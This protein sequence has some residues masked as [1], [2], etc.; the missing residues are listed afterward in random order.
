MLNWKRI[1]TNVTVQCIHF[2]PTV[3]KA[4]CS[5]PR[6]VNRYSLQHSGIC[7]P[8][9]E[10]VTNT[11]NAKN[12]TIVIN[13]RTDMQWL[14]EAKDLTFFRIT[15]PSRRLTCRCIIV[16]SDSTLLLNLNSIYKYSGSTCMCEALCSAQRLQVNRIGPFIKDI[17]YVFACELAWAWFPKQLLLSKFPWCFVFLMLGKAIDIQL[18][19]QDIQ[20]ISQ[21]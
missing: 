15:L 11:N 13:P 18:M 5:V 9:G 1:L 19:A 8:I 4:L 17:L 12:R 20:L 2:A 3:C 21:S 14:K 16:L 6:G 7:I 10:R